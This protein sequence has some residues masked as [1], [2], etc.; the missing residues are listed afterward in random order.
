MRVGDVRVSLEVGDEMSARA[1]PCDDWLP[2][3]PTE[4][5]VLALLLKGRP[6]SREEL[7]TKLDEAVDGRLRGILATLVARKV[8]LTTTDGYAINAADGK[9]QSLREWLKAWDG[10]QEPTSAA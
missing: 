7:A 5:R 9:R 1:M 10:N 8:L 2:F 4:C 3:S 6:L